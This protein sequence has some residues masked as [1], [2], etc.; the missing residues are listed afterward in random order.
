MD[1]LPPDEQGAMRDYIEKELRY[2]LSL[3]GR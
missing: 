2:L 3:L 1:R